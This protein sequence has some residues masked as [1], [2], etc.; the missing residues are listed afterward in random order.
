MAT[1]DLVDTEAA[2]QFLH[3]T[4]PTM[5]GWRCNCVGPRYIKYGRKV[6]YKL[7]DLEA[8]IDR[9]YVDPVLAKTIKHR[10]KAAV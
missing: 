8:F 9:S 6:L 2:A 4:A 7:S 5:V 10:K 3:V 1:D